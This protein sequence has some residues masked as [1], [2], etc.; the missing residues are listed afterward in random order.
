MVDLLKFDTL[1]EYHLQNT[2]SKIRYLAEDIAALLERN[3]PEDNAH[4][5]V[6]LKELLAYLIYLKNHHCSAE[7][8]AMILELDVEEATK[9]LE[10]LRLSFTIDDPLEWL[11]AYVAKIAKTKLSKRTKKDQ[12]LGKYALGQAEDT[13]EERRV[14]ERNSFLHI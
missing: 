4:A 1:N 7:Q 11:K 2:N 6:K 13:A 3:T 10:Q 5:H 14:K 9:L 8:I 12:L